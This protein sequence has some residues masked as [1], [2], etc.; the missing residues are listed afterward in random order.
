MDLTA[1]LACRARAQLITET[2][3]GVFSF[4]LML[5]SQILNF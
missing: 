4:I 1:A 3:I 5:L 2:T